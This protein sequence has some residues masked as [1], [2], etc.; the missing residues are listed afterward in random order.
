[1]LN[2]RIFSKKELKRKKV[3]EIEKMFKSVDIESHRRVQ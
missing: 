2:F 3:L 1:M